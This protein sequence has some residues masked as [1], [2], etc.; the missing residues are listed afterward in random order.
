MISVQRRKKECVYRVRVFLPAG[1]AQVRPWEAS[2][3]CLKASN[4]LGCVLFDTEHCTLKA[5]HLIELKSA[6]NGLKADK[7]LHNL[8]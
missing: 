3:P 6:G 7:E 8:L 5:A 4:G 2:R 1:G